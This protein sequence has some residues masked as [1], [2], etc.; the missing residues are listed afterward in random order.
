[1]KYFLVI[2]ILS[3]MILSSCS[4]ESSVVEPQQQQTVKN[5]WIKI[6]H[7]SSL[8]TENSYTASKSINGSKGGTISLTQPF[9]NN[10]GKWSLVTATLTIPKGSFSGTQIISYTVN[11]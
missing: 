1:M 3:A 11:T 6:N 5:E 7:S 10:D 4:K 2:T 9:K 8:S